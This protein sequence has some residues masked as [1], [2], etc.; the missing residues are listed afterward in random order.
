MNKALPILLTEYGARRRIR[1]PLKAEQE[2][3][4]ITQINSLKNR[5]REKTFL[6]RYSFNIKIFL[7]KKLHLQF[8]GSIII[9]N[10]IFEV[11]I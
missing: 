7:L 5:T 4:K 6:I 1:N 3:M 2:R 8:Y 9:P 11:S 10:L